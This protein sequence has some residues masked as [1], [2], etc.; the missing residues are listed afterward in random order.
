MQQRAYDLA[1]PDVPAPPSPI[2]VWMPGAVKTE[3]HLG[4]DQTDGRFCLLAD[5]PPADWSLPSHRHERESESILIVSGTFEM[6]VEGRKTRLE[7]GDS[8]HIP[9]NVQHAGRSLGNGVGRRVI[10]FSPSGM[11]RFFAEVGRA[12]EA[13]EHDPGGALEAAKRFGWRFGD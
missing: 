10:V 13:E 5:E 4:S 9:A 11:E 6:E 1:M 12:T 8:I 3:I 2:V 7:P